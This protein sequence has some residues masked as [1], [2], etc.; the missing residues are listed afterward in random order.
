MGQLRVSFAGNI[1]EAFDLNLLVIKSACMASHQWRVAMQLL[2][3]DKQDAQHAGALMTAY[4]AGDGDAVV[5]SRPR[6]TECVS[7]ESIEC[8]QD[9]YLN[10][11]ARAND[12]EEAQAYLSGFG[13]A[14]AEKLPSPSHAIRPAAQ[15]IA[16]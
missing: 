3:D 4:E 9:R 10:Y 13:D 2:H 7:S 1:G 16:A 6:G 14:A 11:L 5:L 8:I 15:K 12:R